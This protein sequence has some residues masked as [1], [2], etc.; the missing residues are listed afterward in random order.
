MLSD[1]RPTPPADAAPLR[2]GPLLAVAALLIATLTAAGIWVEYRQERHAEVARI[3]AI[4]ALHSGQISRWLHERTAAAGF[5]SGVRG[6]GD[7]YLRW[8]AGDAAALQSTLVRLT[9]VRESTGYQ[10]V[11]ILDATGGVVAGEAGAD[12]A[13]PPELRAAGLRAI[14]GG[15]IERTE[16]YG[17]KAGTPRFDVVVPLN[18]T[19]RA[20]PAAV[21]FR[22]ELGEFL[23]PMLQA[24]PVASKSGRTVVVRRVGDYIIGDP[25]PAPVRLAPGGLAASVLDGKAPAGV[26]FDGVDSFGVPVLG[27]VSPIE[28]SDWAV[29]A[30]VDLAEVRSAAAGGAGMILALGVLAWVAAAFAILRSRDRQALRLSRARASEHAD[31]LRALMLL[32]SIS[33]ESPDHIYAKDSEGR[34]T[35]FNRAAGL[36][37]G[38]DPALVIGRS[39]GDLRDTATAEAASAE[40]A[41]V[42]SENRIVRSEDAHDTPAGWRSFSLI[43]G[44]LHDAAGKVVGVFGI[45]RDVTEQKA[46]EAELEQHRQHLEELVAERSADLLRANAALA[47][48]ETFLRTV[49][50]NLPARVAYWRGDGM[51]MFVNRAYADHYRRTREEFVGHKST[52]IFT[53][54][55]ISER[56]GRAAAVMAGEAQRFELEE[57]KADGSW[58]RTWVHYIP[59][60]LGDEVRGF[61]VLAADVTEIKTTELR[62]QLLNQELVDARNRAEAASIAKSAFLANMSHEIRTPMNAIIGLTHL[63]HRDSLVPVQ[64]ERLGKVADAAHH[65]LAVINDILDLS[66]IESGKLKLEAIDFELD[67]MLARVGAL[68]GDDARV[69]GLELVVDRDS[70]PRMLRGDPTRLSQALLNLLG[71][72]VKF[73]AAGSVALRCAVVERR[74]DSVLV[75]F[76]VRDTGI[77]IAA[78]KLAG[79]FGAFEQA[80]SSTT[81]RFGGSGLGLSIT[82]QLARLMGGEAGVESEPG[83]GST[84]W[85]TARLGLGR[86]GAEPIADPLLT[87]ERVLLADDLDEARE[88]LAETLRHLGMRVD[89]VASGEEALALADIADATGDPYSICVFDWL[90]PG[91]DGVETCRRLKAGGRR[92]AV[93]CVLVTAHDDEPMRAAARQAGIGCVVLKPASASTL[94]EALIQALA[95]G[96]ASSPRSPPG[97]VAFAALRATHHGAHVLLAEDNLVNQEV[98]REL[99]QSAGLRIDI[100]SNG[101]DAVAMARA[102]PYDLI[103][104]D[105]QM[106]DVDGLQATRTLR[107]LP[108]GRLVPIIAM[109]ANAFGEDR[110]ACIDAG[111]NDHVA[112][113]VDPSL[114]YATLLRWLPAREAIVGKPVV[115]AAPE[116][117]FAAGLRARLATI[118]GFDIERGL[119]MF[120]GR[121]DHYLPVLRLFSRSYAEGMPDIDAAIVAGS[122]AGLAAAGHS[123]RGASGSI[124]ALRIE[125]M[126]AGLESLGETDATT[127]HV[128]AA[129]H[130]LQKL[131]IETV[132]ELQ[133]DIDLEDEAAA[134]IDA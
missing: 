73:T 111:M 43:R 67:S 2:A 65:L 39:A 124:G 19:G 66:K 70:L 114:L 100:A 126:A 10:R 89:S 44:P 109:T 103:L 78:D 26:A 1:P 82:R 81:R 68:I 117:D 80:D 21:A 23:V 115:A 32:D 49:A 56:A 101:A 107:S 22:V 87:G 110:Q 61:F 30:K 94:H 6:V 5:V 77:G 47:D 53:K 46:L 51:C 52:E 91:I 9:E 99:L 76:Q 84:F 71:N 13:T 3:E 31:R 72:A 11:F 14:A 63:L 98:A 41:R 128:A 48:A 28:G 15:R 132:R 83:V 42:M 12:L 129:A 102:L 88:A 116:L 62:L 131:L 36:A 50:D 75:R 134:S 33:N 45:S 118:E 133:R 97:Q 130:A 112:K 59:D 93:H 125:Q 37:F 4:A 25:A 69:K 40:D 57:Q 90:M 29:V 86:Q 27:A 120:D 104:M 16:P 122:S 60:K 24:S 8:Q 74:R 108:E 113:P 92:A 20:V 58:S 17:F 79:L 55:G 18:A 123:L 54:Q 127:R 38:I 105:V 106:P 34:Y 7:A 121:M 95:G 35:L 119:E 96:V 64:R 85:F